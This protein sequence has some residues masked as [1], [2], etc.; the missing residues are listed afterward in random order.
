MSKVPSAQDFWDERHSMG[1]QSGIHGSGTDA[2]GD[3]VTRRALRF[4]GDLH[5]KRL[6]DLGSGSGDAALFFAR[7]GA[8]VTAVD[9][10]E[11]AVERINQRA[12]DAKLDTVAAVTCPAQQID[13]LGSFDFIFGALILHHI[14]PFEPFVDTLNKCLRPGGQAFFYE[15]SAK[16][17][18]LIWF[19]ENVVGK[20]WV[21]KYGDPDEF[22]LTE[23][24]VAILARHFSLHREVS[25]V[26][27]FE[28]A[29]AYLLRGHFAPPFKWMDRLLFRTHWGR[30]L[31]YFQ[32]LYLKKPAG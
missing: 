8:H 14:E 32:N 9:L 24:E 16:S 12:V 27:F 4:F 26:V 17:R 1:A 29:A 3:P 18:L 7:Q 31:S 19:R 25:E 11:I 2:T 23:V 13:S 22:P 30:S 15:N 21:P 20:F 10:S 6:L 5:G 28:L